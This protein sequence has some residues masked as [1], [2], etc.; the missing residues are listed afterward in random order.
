MNPQKRNMTVFAKIVKPIPAK[1][2]DWSLYFIRLYR[3]IIKE[4]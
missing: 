1:I 4:R 2:I 3:R